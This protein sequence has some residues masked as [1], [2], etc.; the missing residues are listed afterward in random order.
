MILEDDLHTFHLK[1]VQCNALED[2]V[3]EHLEENQ[4]MG[5]VPHNI[6]E[7][8]KS[9]EAME[10]A[11]K[12]I[13]MIQKFEM[14]KLVHPSEVPSGTPIYMPIWR[15]TWKLDGWMKARL[16]LPGHCQRKGIDYVNSSSPTVAMASF[17]LFLTFCKFRDVTPVHIDI[18][19]AYLHAKVTEDVYMCQPPGFIDKK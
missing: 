14:W 4:Q 11:Q 8:M 19:N 5:D 6:K 9:R 10:A 7:A 17:R 16:C 13:E 2:L 12:E 1:N 3:N 18:R 15:F